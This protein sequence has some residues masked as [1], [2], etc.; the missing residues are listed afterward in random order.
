M[1]PPRDLLLM[2]E[3]VASEVSAAIRS[4]QEAPHDVEEDVG[5]YLQEPPCASKGALSGDTDTNTTYRFKETLREPKPP[6]KYK[7]AHPKRQPGELKQLKLYS[8]T[9]SSRLRSVL[10]LVVADGKL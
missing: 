5:P 7:G 10:Q 4:R 2:P 6:R 1:S 3:F 9:G 8:F